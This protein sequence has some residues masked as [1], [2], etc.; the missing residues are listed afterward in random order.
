[1]IL[2]IEGAAPERTADEWRAA[3]P[4]RSAV[5]VSSL[6]FELLPARTGLP[7]P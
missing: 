7:E 1:M 4:S 2:Y 3:Y 5:L 6:L